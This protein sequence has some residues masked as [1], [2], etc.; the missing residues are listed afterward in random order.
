[1]TKKAWSS[2]REVL[3]EQRPSEASEV[4]ADAGE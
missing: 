1:V 4:A 2:L 3:E